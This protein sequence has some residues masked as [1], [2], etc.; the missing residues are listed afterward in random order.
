MTEAVPE[1]VLDW[2][3]KD[4]GGLTDH[5]SDNEGITKYGVTKSDLTELWGRPAKDSDVKNLSLEEA[6]N[7]FRRLYWNP[8]KCSELPPAI[9]YMVMDA[10]LLHGVYRSS[11]WLQKAVGVRMDGQVG[12]KTIAAVKA[13][14]PAAVLESITASRMARAKS[15]PD[16]RDFGRGWINR[17]TR[18]KTRA[19]KLLTHKSL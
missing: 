17:I 10:G 19:T 11:I 12:P 18:V 16:Y 5:P 9:A 13:A 15:H 6:K 1:Q 14:D 8:L 7:I 3:L 4:E 2:I